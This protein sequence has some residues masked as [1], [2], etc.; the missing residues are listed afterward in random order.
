[1]LDSLVSAVSLF[2]LVRMMAAV[3]EECCSIPFPGGDDVWYVDTLG[4]EKRMRASGTSKEQR[5]LAGIRVHVQGYG[6][7]VV[8]LDQRPLK[9]NA[10]GHKQ[11]GGYSAMLHAVYAASAAIARIEALQKRLGAILSVSAAVHVGGVVL[12]TMG[13]E[14]QAWDAYGRG[15][16][17]ATA[18]AS[19]SAAVMPPDKSSLAISSEAVKETNVPADQLV[20][21]MTMCLGPR[22]QRSIR[23]FRS[24]NSL[25]SASSTSRSRRFFQGSERRG[26]GHSDADDGENPRKARHGGSGGA[27][28][29]NG[30]KLRVPGQI[31]VDSSISGTATGEQARGAAEAEAVPHQLTGYLTDDGFG[32]FGSD[33]EG[34]MVRP[35]DQAENLDRGGTDSYG[36]S[37]GSSTSA[38]TDESAEEMVIERVRLRIRGVVG[39]WTTPMHA[40]I[41]K[42]CCSK[43]EP[44]GSADAVGQLKVSH[45]SRGGPSLAG[46]RRAS[47]LSFSDNSASSPA[48]GC[49][50]KRRRSSQIEVPTVQTMIR[51]LQVGKAPS[52]VIHGLSSMRASTSMSRH[53]NM[54]GSMVG[55]ADGPAASPSQR[56]RG[57]GELRSVLSFTS[58]VPAVVDSQKATRAGY[59]SHWAAAFLARLKRLRLL[60]AGAFGKVFMVR[61]VVSGAP[62]ALKL[63]QK[64]QI[65]R[66]EVR[67]EV[68]SLAALP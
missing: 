9:L 35:G 5:N 10:R 22:K 45:S 28:S 55:S 63:F 4:R 27:V 13:A 47:D 49:V 41:L 12:G 20:E 30:T 23:R 61:D 21:D 11:V 67:S 34:S 53:G 56:G 68:V 6:M 43:F 64:K 17:D 65:L 44:Q 31:S 19:A 58:A 46:V 2:R 50:L 15:I 66:D 7:T 42:L 38:G 26:G 29:A 33:T 18:L 1:M 62:A 54:A 24:G 14:G 59:K 57:D 36:F 8:F 40:R 16:S 32:A 60:G 51:W 37:K 52:S 39:A 3:V 48:M 25:A